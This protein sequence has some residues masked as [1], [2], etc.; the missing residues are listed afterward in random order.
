VTVHGDAINTDPVARTS[1]GINVSGSNNLIGGLLPGQANVVRYNT[2]GVD[3][4]GY[5]ISVRGNVISEN[6]SADLDIIGSASPDLAGISFRNDPGDIDV[7]YNGMQNYP[8]LSAALTDAEGTRIDGYLASSPSASFTID[9]YASDTVHPQGFGGADRHLGTTSVM[10][11]TDGHAAISFRIP[12]VL[13]RGTWITA[14]ATDATGSTS[15]FAL[16]QPVGEE[17]TPTLV[18]TAAD[19]VEDG[20]CS[21]EHCSLREALRGANNYPGLNVIEFAIPGSGPFTIPLQRELPIVMEPVLID[22]YSQPGAMENTAELGS[23]AV[24]KIGIVGAGQ[25]AGEFG[26]HSSFSDFGVYSNE[27]TIRGLSFMHFRLELS[28]TDFR[29]QGNFF[30][31]DPTGMIRAFSRMRTEFF[32]MFSTSDLT[33]GGSDLRHRNA[34]VAD[35]TIYSDRTVFSGN[36]IGTNMTGRERPVRTNTDYGGTITIVGND[37]QF[38]GVTIAERNVSVGEIIISGDSATILNNYIGLGAHGQ[39]APDQDTTIWPITNENGLTVGG[40]NNRIGGPEPN[41]GNVISWHYHNGL[42][43]GGTNTVVQGN[44][45]GTDATGTIPFGNGPILG[46]DRINGNGIIVGGSNNLIGGSEP[47]E[48]N[49]IAYNFRAGIAV[50]SSG[51]NIKIEGN[52]IFD[53]GGLGI[54]SGNHYPVIDTV[55][56]AGGTT[57]ISGMLSG[58]ANTTHRL[59]FFANRNGDPSGSGEGETIIGTADVSTDG[60]GEASFLL[61]FAFVL[62]E[63][64]LVT[65]TSTPEGG[66]TS[67]FAANVGESELQMTDL[68]ITARLISDPVRADQTSVIGV[69]VTNNGPAIANGIRLEVQA[70]ELVLAEISPTVPCVTIFEIATCDLPSLAPGES[71]D[72]ELGFSPTRQGLFDYNIAVRANQGDPD[73]GNNDVSLL[74]QILPPATADLYASITDA[75]DPVEPGETLVYSVEVGN[76]GDFDA[77]DI[78]LQVQITGHSAV[79]DIQPGDNCSE[80]GGLVTCS[81]DSLASGQSTQIDISIEVG[82]PGTFMSASAEVAAAAP[83]DPES[84]NNTVV[85]SSYVADVCES[86]IFASAHNGPDGISSLYSIDPDTGDTTLIGSIGFERVGGMAFEP[87]TGILYASG[88]RADGSDT[89]VLI[90]I[91]PDT[92]AGIEIG[93]LGFSPVTDIAFRAATGEL[94]AFGGPG[95]LYLVSTGTGVTTQIWLGLNGGGLVFSPDDRLYLSAHD[96]MLRELDPETAEVLAESPMTYIPNVLFRQRFSGLDFDPKTGRY[97]GIF[98]EGWPPPNSWFGSLDITNSEGTYLHQVVD[99]MDGIAI[100]CNPAPN[101]M[102]RDGFESKD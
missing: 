85:E 99:G 11:G 73:T 97:F 21:V 1:V 26:R 29:F 22:G 39:P 18:V 96:S 28:G 66:S 34:I 51:S 5:N 48:G 78:G 19:D 53:N 45:I 38:G 32:P 27:T 101:I 76:L 64:A 16:S 84:S 23:N 30:G 20:D 14:T 71:A 82:P 98:K 40:N 31:L 43:V 60:A 56:H 79:T 58:P 90:E 9:F 67:A 62:P 44:F 63:G 68:A 94:Y 77:G 3:I 36:T 17:L 33:V 47:G 7:G 89:P 24:V 65:A 70:F 86:S 100:S 87:G 2:S 8:V 6:Y 13:E 93:E 83:A 12:N 59:E 69:T 95:E 37:T 35:M 57:S 4:R 46:E 91:N 102:F 15:I 72:Y 52:R 42:R 50:S 88:E 41:Q 74:A 25:E 81:I 92:G 54:I 61:H 80:S 49:L 75:P 55:A 10:T